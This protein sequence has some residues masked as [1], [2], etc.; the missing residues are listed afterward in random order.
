MNKRALFP[1]AV[2][3]FFF[4]LF[5]LDRFFFKHNNSFCLHFI[6]APLSYNPAWEAS[7]PFPEET[8][9]QSYKY[10]SKGSQS[11]VFESEDGKWVVKFYKFPSHMRA[12]SWLKHPLSY[13]WDQRRISIKKHNLDRFLLSFN[14]Y[15]LAWQELSSETAVAYVHLNPTCHLGKALTLIDTLGVH[16]SVPLDSMA[17]ILQRKAEDIFQVLDQAMQ[18]GDS[19]LGKAIV[20]SLI[21]VISSRCYKGISDLDAM[22]NNNYGWLDDHAVHIDVGRFTRDERV[23][24]PAVC[25]EE[26][27]RITQVFSDHLGKNYPEL[28]QHYRDK[29][30]LIISQGKQ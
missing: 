21:D 30:E 25:K 29:L 16:Y 17:F 4:A 28:Y 6:Q 2:F 14:S 18:R 1:L 5:P 20:D 7:A 12:L 11:F 13:A 19:E 3:A 27:Q 10:L 23:K 22:A 26:V 24:A 8:L 15:F 9:S